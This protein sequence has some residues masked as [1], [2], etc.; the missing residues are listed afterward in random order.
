M[1]ARSQAGSMG[2]TIG[3]NHIFG[4]CIS[5][6]GTSRRLGSGCPAKVGPNFTGPK[7]TLMPGA[8]LGSPLWLELLSGLCLALSVRLSFENMAFMFLTSSVVGLVV[9]VVRSSTKARTDFTIG[10]RPSS[11]GSHQSSKP[12]MFQCSDILVRKVGG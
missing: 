6:S 7:D 12:D 10:R 8:A 9:L 5:G 11:L 4:A 2:S 1:S 3:S